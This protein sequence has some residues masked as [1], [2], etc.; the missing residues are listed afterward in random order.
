[1]Y[2]HVAQRSRLVSLPS[3]LRVSHHNVTHPSLW[4][5]RCLQVFDVAALP[6]PEFSQSMGL[7]LPPRLRFL[8][9][10]GGK[11]RALELGGPQPLTEDDAANEG[12]AMD[13]DGGAAGG[14]DGSDGDQPAGPAR[15]DGGGTAGNI[16][17]GKDDDSDD[18]FLVVKKRDVLGSDDDEEPA[19]PGGEL[20]VKK[21]K[22]KK[23]KIKVGH[24]FVD[25]GCGTEMRAGRCCLACS[26][27]W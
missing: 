13:S 18:D 11:V 9:R 21:K 7:L 6:V 10:V 8:K 16:T 1:M 23:Q 3:L 27:S 5:P 26:C 22:K 12:T 20:P 19:A 25:S 2:V 4:L 15:R 14:G 17:A 24:G